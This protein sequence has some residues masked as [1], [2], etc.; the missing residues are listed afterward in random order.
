VA[1]A[2]LITISFIIDNYWSTTSSVKAVQKNISKY[3][4]EQENDFDDL[5][6][7]TFLINKL[8]NKTYDRTLLTQLTQKQYYFFIYWQNDIGLYNLNFWNTQVIEPEGYLFSLKDKSGFIQLSNGYYVWRK[9]TVGNYNSLALIPV[10]WN[11]SI[12]NEYLRNSFVIGDELDNDFDLAEMENDAPVRSKEGKFLFSLEQKSVTI[13]SHN[14]IIASILRLIA[15]LVFLLFIH[16]VATFIVQRNFYKG[17]AFLL[18]MIVALRAIS[19]YLPIPLNFRQFELFDPA[20][21]AANIVLRSLGDLL[22]NGLLFLWIVLFIRHYIQEKNISFKIHNTIARGLVVLAGI[23]IL[24]LSTLVCGH[25]ILSMVADSQIS[26]DVINFFTFFH[27]KFFPVALHSFFI[28]DH[29]ITV[30]MRMPEYQ[31]FTN[32][33]DHFVERKVVIFAAYPGVK[34]NVQQ[35]VTQFFPDARPIFT[36]DSIR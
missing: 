29:N 12:T 27:F 5:T 36:G 25:I 14:N 6:K 1:A 26:F 35:D 15:A 2:W 31:F 18:V 4:A 16:S 11:Y 21:Y 19:Y 17:V 20:V 33:I 3:I 34:Y 30:N 10:K 13:I 7:D 24:I 9:A 32:S 8:V 23:V 22:I 28:I